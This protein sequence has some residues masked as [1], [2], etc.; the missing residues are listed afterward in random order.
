MKLSCNASTSEWS[1]DVSKN[2][3]MQLSSN[4]STWEISPTARD[5]LLVFEM[6]L[7]EVFILVVVSVSSI[8]PVIIVMSANRSYTR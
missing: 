6:C 2:S 4:A 5:N 3:N 8:M 7:C 1:V